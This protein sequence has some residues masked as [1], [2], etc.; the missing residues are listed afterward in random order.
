[1]YRGLY[2]IRPPYDQP[3]K[4]VILYVYV[5]RSIIRCPDSPSK[6][7]VLIPLIDSNNITNKLNSDNQQLTIRKILET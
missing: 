3:T 2:T 7:R 4:G 6:E 1:M 5:I